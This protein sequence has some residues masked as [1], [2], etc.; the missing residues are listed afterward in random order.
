MAITNGETTPPLANNVVMATVG[1]WT[2]TVQIVA[3]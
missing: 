3:R 2:S 1:L